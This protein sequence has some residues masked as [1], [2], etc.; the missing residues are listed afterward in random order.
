MAFRSAGAPSFAA[1][2]STRTCRYRRAPTSASTRYRTG[3]GSACH[4]RGSSPSARDSKS[5]PIRS[6]PRSVGKPSRLVISPL[7][8]LL[9]REYP[10]DIY[11][12][13]GAHVEHLARELR[14]RLRLTVHCWGDPRPEPD[15][16][17]H[18]AW[19]DLAEPMPEAAALQALSIDLRMVAHCKGVQLVH[20][21]T[22]YA[23]LAGHLAKL[24]WGVP[25]VATTHSLEP[26]R[27]WKAEQ[28]GGGYQ[29]SSFCEETALEAA[30]AVIAVS[31]GMRRDVLSCYPAIEEPRVH[32]IHNGI[33]AQA[34]R[35]DPSPETLRRRGVDPAHPYA[36]FVGRVTR[37]KGLSHLLQAA[38]SMPERCQL[39]VCAG[40]PD[41]PEIAA[42]V[43]ALAD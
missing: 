22:W 12:G 25:H 7:V 16:V 32:V 35:P 1:P 23:N 18:T 24:T 9:T 6:P 39:V 30:D 26:L 38:L 31:D 27:P 8:A 34:Y 42:E 14:S 21:H 36:I 20:S 13:A 40:T 10:P 4:R 3:A 33:D 37:Q 11:G 41:T 29:V 17:A 43:T 28:L 15:V 2:S 19:G 5:P